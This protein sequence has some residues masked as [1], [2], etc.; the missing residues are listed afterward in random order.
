[1]RKVAATEGSARSSLEISVPLVS[2]LEE[3]TYQPLVFLNVTLASEEQS[4]NAL[5]PIEV[6]LSG[7]V[8]LVSEEQPENA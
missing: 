8:M 6:T 2:V 4:S 1:M 7:M 5:R 3:E